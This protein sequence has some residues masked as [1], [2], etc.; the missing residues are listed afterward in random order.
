M[1][2]RQ[3]SPTS[4]T[5]IVGV[6][7][8]V[9]EEDLVE[10]RRAGELADRPDLDAGLLHRDE[11]VGQALV[12]CR[13]RVRCGPATKHQSATWAS[14]VQTFCPVIDHSPSTSGPTC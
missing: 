6:G 14:D 2:T 8:G 11:Q 12:P 13:A 1:A 9:V 3:P 5:T 4:P 7:A 10:L